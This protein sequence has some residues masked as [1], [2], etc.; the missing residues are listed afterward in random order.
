MIAAYTTALIVAAVAL[1]GLAVF[2]PGGATR[3]G[4]QFGRVVLIACTLVSAV[5]LMIDGA[6]PVFPDP[7]PA[8]ASLNDPFSPTSD[9]GAVV[10]FPPTPGLADASVD[11]EASEDADDSSSGSLLDNLTEGLGVAESP[12][13]PADADDPASA[14]D[15]PTPDDGSGVGTVERP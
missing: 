12:D 4:W 5:M 7:T 14:I 3:W 10:R 11:A 1:A 2:R 13:E 8:A 6:V 15:T 9:P